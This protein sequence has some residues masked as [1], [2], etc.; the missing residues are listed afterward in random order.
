[1]SA[2]NRSQP[3]PNLIVD[4][5]M[6]FFINEV[7]GPISVL[8]AE[9]RYIYCNDILLQNN[10][11]SREEM[12]GNKLGSHNPNSEFTKV[13]TQF[14]QSDLDTK[15]VR[16]VERNS[17]QVYYYLGYLK[18]HHLNGA[19]RVFAMSF[20]IS[21]LQ[22]QEE[23]T[24]KRRLE[25]TE[26]EKMMALGE[27]ASGV[28][29]E[30]N[31]PLAIINGRLNLIKKQL[32]PET[33]DIEKLKKQLDGIDDAS[34][35]IKKVVDSLK[36]I[37]KDS[38]EG[39]LREFT[40]SEFIEPMLALFNHRLFFECINVNIDPNYP[41]VNVLCSF[42]ELAQVFLHLIKNTI[43]ALK[44]HEEKWV[45]LEFHVLEKCV[46]IWVTDSG[47]G[48]PTEI[49]AQ[50]FQPFFTTKG[51]KNGSGIGLASA[52]DLVRKQGGDLFYKGDGPNTCFVIEIPLAP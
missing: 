41:K 39:D 11:L 28:A 16:F 48:I 32:K 40:F 35:R 7:P 3:C 42:A 9:L 4:S 22:I 14:Y 24:E 21:E 12:I 2:L 33:L 13:V 44:G 31:N 38:H 23:L 8:D 27:I 15:I 18:K 43:D 34:K 45:K 51:L 17:D 50:I 30:V 37:S 1:M 36:L 5:E 49:Q 29:H 10:G 26:S 20:D 25:L 46:H 19:L 47:K 52:R 6:E